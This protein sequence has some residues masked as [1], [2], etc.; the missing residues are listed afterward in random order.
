MREKLMSLLSVAP[1]LSLI[2]VVT[3]FIFLGI[4]TPSESAAMGVVATMFLAACYG[5]L[6]WSAAQVSLRSAMTTTAMMLLVVVGSSGFS[7][8]LAATG[9]TSSLVAAVSDL[10]VSPIV[11]VILMQLIVLV[12]GCFIDTISIMLVAIPV[13]MPVVLALSIDPIW[14]CVLILVQLELAGITPPFG[15][16]LFVMK[17]VQRRLKISEIYLAAMPIV[18]IQLLLVALMMLFPAIVL[19]LPEMMMK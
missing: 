4:A 10:A 14:F 12:L 7:Q 13:F 16:L 19:T 11:T 1:M 5:R 3:G 8:L 2:V 9:A 18:F 6:T 17:G 15:V